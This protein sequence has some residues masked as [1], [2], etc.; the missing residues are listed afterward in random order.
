[1]ISHILPGC[2]SIIG[3]TTVFIID[4]AVPGDGNVE[5]KEKEKQEKYLAREISRL[6]KAKT[7]LIPIVVE[8]LGVIP[9]NLKGLL[10]ETKNPNRVR[11]LLSLHFLERPPS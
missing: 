11:T 9:K 1:M 2:A 3:T 8:A 4:I 10:R 5:S 6:W 7:K